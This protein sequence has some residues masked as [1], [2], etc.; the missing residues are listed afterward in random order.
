MDNENQWF[1]SPL[2]TLFRMHRDKSKSAFEECERR[3]SMFRKPMPEELDAY[4]RWF[5]W[6]S[7]IET[8][9]A[10]KE[11]K[12]RSMICLKEYHAGTQTA[13]SV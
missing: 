3:L 7:Q 10:D 5:K 6:Q 4:K 8:R 11:A 2:F 13:G 1:P 9:K 12:R